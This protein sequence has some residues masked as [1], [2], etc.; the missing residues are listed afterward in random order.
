[1]VTILSISN[2]LGEAED[3]YC[4]KQKTQFES[5]ASS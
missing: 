3:F 2:G 1:M 4:D 5:S